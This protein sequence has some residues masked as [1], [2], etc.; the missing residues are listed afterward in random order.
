MAS[1]RKAEVLQLLR[2][3]GEYVSGQQICESFG[4]S[5]TAVWKIINQLKEEGYEIEAVQNKGYHL[6]LAPDILSLSELQSRIKTKMA[7][8]HLLY[9]D[10]IDSTNIE[11]KKQAEMNAPE[12]LLV[13]A[14]K[15]EAGRGR[16]GRSW[17]SPAGANIFM[18]ILLRPS[19]SP[20]RASMVTLVMAISV[21][22]AITE[23]AELDAK[24]KWPNDIVVNKKKVVGIL[25]ELTM[26]TDY[27][28]YLVCGVG[29][30]VNQTDFPEA[31]R[32]TATSL[33]LEGGKKINRAVL[34]E[35]T[36]EH[37]EENYGIFCRTEDMSG[38]MEAYNA[39]LVNNGAQVRV[40][41]PK[42][43]YD[44]LS[45]GINELGELIVEKGDG[46]VENVYAGEVSVR[47]IYGYV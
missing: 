4:I 46:S 20:E 3:S 32:E 1:S 23:A 34:I 39:L 15:Q 7:G 12:G 43:E 26:E 44:G 17:E 21:A 45:R 29:I 9:F 24:I 6:A 42:G 25:T 35:K 36:M 2:D 31:I 19:F 11:A 13:V 40:L 28:Q 38:L 5:R 30:N 16:R 10:V 22:Q 8:S 37:F 18:T 33:Y 27:I 41:D 14:D 47:G